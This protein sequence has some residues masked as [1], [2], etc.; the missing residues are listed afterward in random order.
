MN[1]GL[2]NKCSVSTDFETNRQE[3]TLDYLAKYFD[4]SSRGID[5]TRYLQMCETM[6]DIPDPNKIPPEYSDFPTYVH[7]AIEIFNALPDTYSGGMSTVYV[8]KDLASLPVLFDIYLINQ[9]MKM[10]V[11]EVIRFLDNRARKQAVKEA[12]KAAK[13]RK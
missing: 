1:L 4:N 6:G 2:T 13:T 8:G 7:D 3:A 9:G 5:T 10:K 11:F 12:E